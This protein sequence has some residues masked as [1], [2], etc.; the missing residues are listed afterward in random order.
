MWAL[1]GT[2]HP[3]MLLNAA[4]VFL[5]SVKFR[6]WMFDGQWEGV[7]KKD[8]Y[9]SVLG[10]HAGTGGQHRYRYRRLFQTLKSLSLLS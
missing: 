8:S 5:T 2:A 9:A 10:V 4:S 3:D 1:C 6:H 7:S